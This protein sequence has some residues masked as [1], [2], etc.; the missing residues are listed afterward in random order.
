MRGGEEAGGHESYVP[1]AFLP[2][3]DVS[4]RLSPRHN[5]AQQTQVVR[6]ARALVSNYGGFSFVGPYTGTPTLSLY[7][8]PLLSSVH[9]DAI[10]RVARRIGE[11]KRLY[12]ARHVGTLRP[13]E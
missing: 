3:L 8:H 7:S 13:E 4:D 5:L 6:G 10:E 12:R 9:L 2:V 1:P 11:G